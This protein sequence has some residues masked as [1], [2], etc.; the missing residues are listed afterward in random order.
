M[1]KNLFSVAMTGA[2]LAGAVFTSCASED[3]PATPVNPIDPTVVT[4]TVATKEFAGTIAAGQTRTLSSDTTYFLTGSVIVQGTLNIEPGTNILARKGFDKYILVDRGGK[5]NAKG[6]ADKP[7]TFRAD[8]ISTE[9]GYWG[10]LIINGYA[11]ISGATTGTTGSTEIN[12]AYVYGGTNPAD[13]SGTLTYVKLINT[14]AK[15]SAEVEHN[16]LTLNAVGN[17]TTINNIY[18]A[19]CADDAI[20][21]F[22]GSVNVTNLL[23]V[24]AE[25]D[26]F[27]FTQGYVGTL[28][29]VYGYWSAKMTSDE[30]DPRGVEGDGNLD[31]KTSTDI[32]QSVATIKNMTLANY[33]TTAA[34]QDAI[35][36]RRGATATITNALVKGTGSV[37]D[38]ID[39][40]DSRGAAVE[41]TSVSL[42][43]QLSKS[44]TGKEVNGTG[45]ANFVTTNTGANTSAF[46]W[47]GTTA[48]L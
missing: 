34:W 2:L 12:V 44:I 45:I 28:D 37:T 33:S 18:V 43:N 19:Y 15:S 29:N 24:D 46:A 7:I 8:T 21:F 42:T 11:P 48:N 9:A 38:L 47:T 41:T 35:K 25:D 14:G 27:D 3:D 10:G 30:A 31:G 22:G 20:E 17:G 5:I 23:A 36:V 4:P 1:K 40:T 26:Q 6:T 32:N 13:N 39:F 16:G